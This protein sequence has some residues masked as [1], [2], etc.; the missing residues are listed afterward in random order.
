MCVVVLEFHSVKAQQGDSRG[1]IAIREPVQVE[2]GTIIEGEFTLNFE[3]HPYDLEVSAGDVLDLSVIPLGNQLEVGLTVNG[4]SG[5]GVAISRGEF[6]S[7][8]EIHVIRPEANPRIN[9]G[10]LSANGRHRIGVMNHYLDRPFEGSSR[11]IGVYTLFIGCTLRDGT[12]IE[13]GDTIAD[14]PPPVE[15]TNE[16]P[17]TTPAVAPAFGFPGLAPVDFSNGVTVPLQAE[18]PNSGSISPG[19][20]GIFGYS[21]SGNADE[22]VTLEFTRQSGNLNLGIVVLSADNQVAFQASL[23]NSNSLTTEFALPVD[24]DYTIGVFRIELLTVDAPEATSFT[25]SFINEE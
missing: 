6:Y 2:C 9:T 1:N 23:L 13:P 4:P 3:F 18:A 11:G 8:G 19:F 7:D 12:V 17:A 14:D 15:D 25:V 24:G 5:L 20:E 21:F 16:S 22:T 10:Q